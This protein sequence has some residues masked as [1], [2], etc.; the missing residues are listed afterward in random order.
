MSN[1]SRTTEIIASVRGRGRPRTIGSPEE[2]HELI[3]SYIDHCEESGVPI[4]LTGMILHMGLNSR[5]A[6]DNY[7][8]YSQDFLDAVKRAKMIVQMAYE[9]Q[10]SGGNAAGPIFAL[11]N[12]S[13]SDKQELA[14]GNADDKPFEVTDTTRAARLSGLV[15]LANSRRAAEENDDESDDE[16]GGEDLC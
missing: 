6:L 12:M 3:E 5:E 2:M 15:A 13:W 9:I 8:T 7:Q 10:L 4:L 1:P 11:K 14:I 16:S